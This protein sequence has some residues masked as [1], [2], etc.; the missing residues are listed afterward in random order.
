M[1]ESHDVKLGVLS[2]SNKHCELKPLE[3][4]E[5]KMMN[6]QVKIKIFSF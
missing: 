4:D 2:D 6:I 3:A 1:T 5:S